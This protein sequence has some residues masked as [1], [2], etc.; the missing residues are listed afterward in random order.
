[1]EN[2][3]IIIP[4]YNEAENIIPLIQEIESYI[5]PA[6]Q[7]EIIVV[8]DNSPDDTYKIIQEYALAGNKSYIHTIK[9]TW[10]KGL[11]SAVIEGSS[12][13]KFQNIA[14]MDGDG[15]HDP[16]DLPNLFNKLVENELDLVIGSRFSSK[17]NTASLSQRRNRMSSITNS[18]L[19]LVIRK[20]LTDPLSGFF[21]L[22]S[23]LL[24]SN[25]KK[26]Y[27]EGFKILFDVLM[28]ERQLKVQETQINFRKRNTGASKLNLATGLSL[29]GQ[30]LENFTK[31]LFPASFFVF[32]FIGGFGVIVHLS[33]LHAALNLS[34]S[35]LAANFVG[36]ASALISNYFLNNYLTFNNIHK[37]IAERVVGL[38]RYA[39]VNSLSLF[40][41]IGIAAQLY[42]ENFSILFA[43][44]SGIFA[45]LVLNYLLSRNLV[46][47]T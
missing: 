29:V 35:Y 40:A 5:Q 22:K 25:S 9:R 14:V 19:A 10:N 3:S 16:A 32:S 34:A 8:D 4:T 6:K 42:S 36:T 7:V 24:K 43:T 17:K 39:L 1:M 12:I 20:S 38:T 37:S 44:F 31:R 46:F 13:A 23:T 15:Q 45:G 27:K 18:F 11:S 28:I 47:K 21:I 41:N 2:V 33:L 26:L 30:I